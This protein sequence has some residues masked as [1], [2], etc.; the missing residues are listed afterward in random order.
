[1]DSTLQVELKCS[2]PEVEGFQDYFEKAM[3]PSLM[4]MEENRV[5]AQ[6]KSNRNA[7]LALIPLLLAIAAFFAL[8][9][10]IREDALAFFSVGA[11]YIIV[12]CIFIARPMRKVGTDIKTFLM[13]S[14]CSFLKVDYSATDKDFPFK[15]FKDAGLLPGHDDRALKDHVYG[16]Y[17]KIA[18]N[19]VECHLFKTQTHG[20]SDSTS[21]SSETVYHGIL[22]TIDYPD[23]I[24]G[25]TL[26][27]GDSG[28]FRNFFKGLFHGQ[29]I[30]LGHSGLDD[31]YLIHTSDEEEARKLLSPRR[32]EKIMALVEHI[33]PCALEMAFMD[34]YLLL[35]VRIDHSHFAVTSHNPA[36]CTRTVGYIVQEICIIFDLIDILGFEEKTA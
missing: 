13:D 27:S 18:F 5:E 36:T 7:L 33:G 1:M 20:S 12:A 23:P 22:I 10:S 4:E 31:H 32:V 6:K 2:R 30:E 21:T 11:L 16:I 29:K 9:F 26:I 3:Y 24:T 35:S 17:K 34:G 15:V 25:K 8:G 19:L 14:I 28:M